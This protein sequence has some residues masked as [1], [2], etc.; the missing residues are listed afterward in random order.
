MP[1]FL[2][3]AQADYPKAYKD[4]TI[5]PMEGRSLL[6][7]VIENATIERD[8]LCWEHHG[9]RAVRSGAWKLVARGESGPWELYN[10]KDDR[11]ELDNL[12]DQHPQRVKE[13]NNIWW[14]WAK[15]CNVLPMN[16]NKKKKAQTK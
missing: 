2:A 11:T 13:L 12:A 9:N 8:P 4:E 16:P 10:M 14:A 7:A 15:R 1:T 6:A 3:A 5:P